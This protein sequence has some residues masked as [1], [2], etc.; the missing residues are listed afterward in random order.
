[1]KILHCYASPD[2]K[3]FDC[4]QPNELELTTSQLTKELVLELI[5]RHSDGNEKCRMFAPFDT[6]FE[7]SNWHIPESRLWLASRAEDSDSSPISI[8]DLIFPRSD[9]CIFIRARRCRPCSF[10]S[11][12]ELV[13][14]S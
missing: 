7:A 8:A 4:P 1:M 12:E 5:K 3:E 2:F 14:D 13:C 9:L 11:V 6:M 10:Y